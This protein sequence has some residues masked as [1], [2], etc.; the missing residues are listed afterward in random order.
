[1]GTNYYIKPDE[2]E[3]C[4]R[5]DEPIH[6]GKSS[7]GWQFL[8]KAYPDEHYECEHVGGPIVSAADWRKRLMRPNTVIVDEYDRPES[9]ECFWVFVT[10][11]QQEDPPAS[12]PDYPE[13]RDFEY[14][15]PEGFRMGT[16]DF[17]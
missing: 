7:I 5:S 10:N 3:H 14:T 11:K 16:R 15:D 13:W 17:S 12:H 8:F 6:I 9:V 2:C 1:M 4:G